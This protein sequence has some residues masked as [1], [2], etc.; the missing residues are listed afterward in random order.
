M[1]CFSSMA[2]DGVNGRYQCQSVAPPIFPQ[3]GMTAFFQSFSSILARLF[4]R[5]FGSGFIQYR[6]SRQITSGF[7]RSGRVKIRL[8]NHSL[9]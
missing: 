2:G 7:F 8:E 1:P 6:S 5:F 3:Y 9:G 4:I